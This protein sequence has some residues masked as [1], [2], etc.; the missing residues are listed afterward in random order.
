MR[1][2]LKVRKTGTCL[3]CLAFSLESLRG[4]ASPTGSR[5]DAARGC[6]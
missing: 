1:I 2:S 3:T 4:N 5:F 6:Q